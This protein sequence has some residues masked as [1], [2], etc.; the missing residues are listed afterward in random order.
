MVNWWERAGVLALLCDVFFCVV[1]TFRCGVLGQVW[2]LIVS[3]HDV[4]ILSYSDIYLVLAVFDPF[5]HNLLLI[6]GSSEI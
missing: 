4:C 3:I 1:V 5:G 6:L 2:Y